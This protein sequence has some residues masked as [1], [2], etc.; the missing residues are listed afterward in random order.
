MDE[1]KEEILT[2]EEV[3][4]KMKVSKR[5][6]YRL[7]QAGKFPAFKFGKNWRVSSLKLS[8]LFK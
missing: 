3:A 8:E 2:I 6:I 1:Q 4:T 7:I 5:T